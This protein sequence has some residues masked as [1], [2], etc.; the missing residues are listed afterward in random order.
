[1]GGHYITGVADVLRAGGLTVVEVDGWQT[2]ARG[3]GGYDPGR[4]THIM[5]HHT[6]SGPGSDGWPDVSYIIDGSPDAPLANLYLDR[7]G[8]WWILAGGA[9]N[10]N[11]K[12]RDTWGGGVPDDSMNTYAI[13]IEAANDGVGEPWPEAQTDGYLAGVA[14]LCAAYLIPVDHV[15]AHAEWAPDRKVDP[16]GP[17]RWA[18]GP[19]TWNMPHFRDDVDHANQPAPTPT[20]PTP[21]Q[22]DD[23]MRFIYGFTDYTNTFSQEGI[24]LSPEAFDAQIAAGAVLIQSPFHGQHVKSILAA[25]GLTEADL[26]PR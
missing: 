3:S 7:G 21:P 15:R 16:A 13:G 25:S 11:G 12:G 24:H 8:L 14:A 20:P 22:E 2:R 6:A 18:T 5:A 1:M 23:D 26:D 4:P 19:H 9:T 10:T 17:P